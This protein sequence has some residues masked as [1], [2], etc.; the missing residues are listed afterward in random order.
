MDRIK[1]YE[2]KIITL[3]SPF[4]NE[5]K[6]VYLIIDKKKHHYQV[7]RADWD[8]QN[9]YYF[10][11]RI[12]LHINLDGKILVMENQVEEDMAE[13]LVESGVPKSSIILTLLPE[14]VRKHTGYAVA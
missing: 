9:R 14:S 13:L 7:L 1:E 6:G 12:H 11:V 2:E 4:E 8:N 5:A 3:L 10:R